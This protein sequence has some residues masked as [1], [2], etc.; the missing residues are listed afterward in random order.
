MGNNG[1]S[2]CGKNLN[3]RYLQI[4][5]LIGMA[6]PAQNGATF[7][8]TLPAGGPFESYREWNYQ[9]VWP[10]WKRCKYATVKVDF[11]IAYMLSQAQ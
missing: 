7:H 11:E 8:S 3:F 6:T 9:K 4:M 1:R 5:T 2:N 10:C